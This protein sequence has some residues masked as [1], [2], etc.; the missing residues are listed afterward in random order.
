MPHSIERAP[1]KHL[2]RNVLAVALVCLTARV[3]A[4]AQSLVSEVQLGVLAHDVPILG[5]QSEHG[6]DLNGELRFVTPVPNA[7]AAQVPTA[8]RWLLTPRPDIGID[9]N[10]SGYTS[11]AYIGLTWTAVLFHALVAPSDRFDFSIGFGPAFNNG[12]RIGSDD[13]LALGSS[14]LFH[15]SVELAYWF[16]PRWNM[17]LYF[18][19]SS[20]AGLARENAGLDNLGVRLGVGF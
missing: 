1:L 17:S 7:W 20:N 4:I 13:H 5:I 12:R 15:P 9:A 14:V 3:H 10:A 8:L 2:L 6:A 19:H 18:E 11:Q 16:N